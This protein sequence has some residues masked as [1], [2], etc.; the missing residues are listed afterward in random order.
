MSFNL[1]FVVALA[2]GKWKRA[3]EIND[4]RIRSKA[5]HMAM[6]WSKGL[7]AEQAAQRY[8]DTNSIHDRSCRGRILTIVG[9]FRIALA[10][11]ASGDYH[12]VDMMAMEKARDMMDQFL[13]SAGNNEA[14]AAEVRAAIQEYEAVIAKA[15]KACDAQQ[16]AKARL[17]KPVIVDGVYYESTKAA[18][19]ATGIPK[20]TII[21]R[22]KAGKPGYSRIRQRFAVDRAPPP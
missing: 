7:T 16:A 15:N 4:R 3:R 2:E 20:R 10:R 21:D 13:C 11:R 17:S 18:N 12:T 9:E 1:L 14:E 5:D 22:L 19:R 8:N 6:Y